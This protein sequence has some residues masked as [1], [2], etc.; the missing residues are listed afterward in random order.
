MPEVPNDK[1]FLIVNHEVNNSRF[2]GYFPKTRQMPKPI[3]AHFGHT[4]NIDFQIKN[5][6]TFSLRA[7]LKLLSA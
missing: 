5:K 1:N 6:L 3:E 4:K 7:L 2:L